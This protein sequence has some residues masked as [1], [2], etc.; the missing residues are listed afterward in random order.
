[1]ELMNIKFKFSGEIFLGVLFELKLKPGG[2]MAE[3]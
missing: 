2:Y 3:K 1:M